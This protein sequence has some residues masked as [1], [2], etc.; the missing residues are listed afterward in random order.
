MSSA[1]LA[2]FDKIQTAIALLAED[3]RFEL[4]TPDACKQRLLGYSANLSDWYATCDDQ[5]PGMVLLYPDAMDGFCVIRVA[6]AA[7]LDD[8][9][10]RQYLTWH[11]QGTIK[12]KPTEKELVEH[13]TQS[14]TT[15]FSLQFPVDK[16]RGVGPEPISRQV[17]IIEPHGQ[18]ALLIEVTGETESVEKARQLIPDIPALLAGVPDALQNQLLAIDR[19]KQWVTYSQT[20]LKQ[21]IH[22]ELNVYAIHMAD[23][24]VGYQLESIKRESDDLASSFVHVVFPSHQGDSKIDH[25]W[26]ADFDKQVYQSATQEKYGQDKVVDRTLKMADGR[27]VCESEKLG[28]EDDHAD[29]IPWPINEDFWPVDWFVK[30]G[31]LDQWLLIRAAYTAS[32]PMLH[33]VKLERN[34]QG[35]RLLRR[36][37]ICADTNQYQFDVQGQFKSLHGFDFEAGQSSTLS[38]SVQRIDVNQVYNH[39]PTHEKAIAQWIKDHES[40]AR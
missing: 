23:Q 40:T 16:D 1:T 3:K 21:T 13:Q 36:P 39:W 32:P 34:E 6:R 14:N 4:V 2:R 35:Y 22:D 30:Q 24:W 10:L 12:R 31:W 17:H 15:W 8:E 9:Q 27:I 18:A 19:G 20:H 26:E 7:S 25:F 5:S 28:F 37:A 38:L 33:W 29:D 11:F